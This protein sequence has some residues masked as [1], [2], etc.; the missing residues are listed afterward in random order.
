MAFDTVIDK[1]QFEGAITASANAIREK[2]GSTGKIAWNQTKGFADAISAIETGGGGEIDV[3]ILGDAMPQ[4]VKAGVIFSSENGIAQVGTHV[5]SG[6]TGGNPVILKVEKTMYNTYDSSTKTTYDDEEFIKLD[7]YPKSGGTVTVTYGGV[8]RTI[9]DD[10]TSETPPAQEVI[11]GTYIGVDYDDANTPAS[12]SLLI[13]GDYDA[14]AVGTYK[15]KSI[16]GVCGCIT[17]VVS[18]GDMDYIPK[19][20]FGGTLKGGC[21][22]LRFVNLPYNLKSIGNDAFAECTNLQYLAIPHGITYIPSKILNGSLG[23][24]DLIIPDSVT[25]IRNLAFSESYLSFVT[26][27]ASV[28]KIYGS[29]F[30]LP[31]QLKYI[32][33]LASTPPT[34]TSGDI[35][36][37]EIPEKFEGFLIP[38]GSSAA[39]KAADGWSTYADYYV[40]EAEVEEV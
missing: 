6:G 18:F 24:R 16:S 34:M 30:S 21:K 40:E 36:G 20:C 26:I 25:E 7:I 27:P 37:G 33:M 23:V 17:E 5:C 13:E 4:D 11:F 35:F 9:V 2:T 12:G 28:T 14:F 39:Y 15:G 3:S 1:A 29:A 32:R 19:F 22:K 8:V 10:G 38:F 31:Y